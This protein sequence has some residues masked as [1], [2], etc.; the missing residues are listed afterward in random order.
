MWAIGTGHTK[1][2]EPQIRALLG[3]AAHSCKVVEDSAQSVHFILPFLFRITLILHK[4]DKLTPFLVG[5]VW[6]I[7]SGLVCDKETAQSVHKFI[8]DWLAKVLCRIDEPAEAGP[9]RWTYRGRI[10]GRPR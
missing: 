4:S 10:D 3:T 8:R 7:G 1:V 9:N 5:Q 2:Y 6:A